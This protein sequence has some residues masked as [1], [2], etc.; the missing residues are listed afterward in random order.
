MTKNSYQLIVISYQFK[1]KGYY[2]LI[3]ILLLTACCLLPA[4][5]CFA[6]EQ[7]IITSEALEYN[8]DTSTYT[9]KG[10]V[11]IQRAN[12][13]I[14]SNALIYNEQTSEIFAAGAIRYDDPDVSITTNRAEFNLETKTG[15][16]Y[17][18]EILFKKDNY[19]I[20][21][22]KIEKKGDRDYFSP[23]ATFTTCDAPVPAWCF[24]GKDIDAVVGE[25]LK[26]KGVSFRI[27]DVPVL[28]T[29]YLRTSFQNER[30]TGFLMPG[31]GFSKK[32]GLNVNI[33]FFLAIS[34][35]RDA[36]VTMD[37]YT[38]RGIGEGLEYRYIESQNIN[39]RM[40]AL[41]YKRQRY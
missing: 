18:A 12:I 3:F 10:N 1:K 38:K 14:E 2:L 26:S 27:K 15:M 11:K 13:T 6:E 24:K 25:R 39:G 20:T 8:G 29:P 40:V 16:L 28:Y 33:P 21:G 30:Q 9:V 19:H 7:T 5:C 32:S 41:S 34:E 31:I 36:T 37:T 17:D 22:K 23:E 4:D 35:N